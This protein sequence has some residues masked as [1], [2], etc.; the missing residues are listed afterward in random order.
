[1]Y[2]LNGESKHCI[3]VSDRGFQYGDGLFETIEVSNG[4]PLFLD[5]HLE[6]LAAGC[7]RLLIPMPD[8][9]LLRHE[10]IQLSASA[11]QAVLKLIVTRGSGGRGYR[12]PDCI[13]PT[14]LFSL[15]PY[16]DYPHS[17]QSKGVAARF[18]RHRL[19]LNP[20]LAGLKHLNRLEQVMARAEWQGSDIQEGL[21]S[22]EEGFVI[23]GTMSNVFAV[24]DGIL[25]TA[26]IERCG[27]AGI[28]RALLINVA[29]DMGIK[30]Q[31]RY[32]T[33]EKLLRADEI[34]VTNSVI[35]IWP[36]R[37]LETRRFEP[38]P[39]TKLFQKAYQ[40]MRQQEVGHA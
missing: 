15:H 2:L 8:R 36:V 20:D 34:F 27:V 5:L 3:D 1:M 21:M 35:G 9:S 30:V 16:P 40:Q 24:Q 18:C 19:G 13:Q 28:V 31:E 29:G 14:R 11:V 33:S 38:G 7:E 25:L 32:F 26:P 23:E 17:Y 12:Q 6:R 10:A 22:N 39:V 37:Q 4:K